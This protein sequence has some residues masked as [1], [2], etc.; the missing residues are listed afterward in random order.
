M[1]SNG[2]PVSR[3]F[4]GAEK[5]SC[6]ILW[7]GNYELETSDG[8]KFTVLHFEGYYIARSRPPDVLKVKEQW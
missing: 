2:D 6:Q 4:R 5:L 7:N 3:L 8:Q 1:S